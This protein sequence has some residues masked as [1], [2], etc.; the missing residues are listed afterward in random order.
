VIMLDADHFKRVNDQYGHAAGDTV[1]RAIG[2]RLQATLRRSDVGC[3]YGG[4]EFVLLLPGSGIAAAS[5]VAERVR[6]AIRESPIEVGATLLNVTVSLGVVGSDELVSLR[7]VPAHALLEY[8]DTALYEAK[9]TGRDRV[10]R[11]NHESRISRA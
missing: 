11:Y 5:M 8:A 4:E 6:V 3:R 1:L 7:D 9:R 10:C 2:L